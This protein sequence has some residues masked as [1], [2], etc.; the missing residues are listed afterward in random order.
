V[1][2]NQIHPKCTQSCEFNVPS[3]QMLITF[4][5]YPAM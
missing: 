4:K 2:K 5:M 1:G 3:G